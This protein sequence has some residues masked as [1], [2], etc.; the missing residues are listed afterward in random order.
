MG[1]DDETGGGFECLKAGA[2]LYILPN[3]AV[4]LKLL[5]K[6]KSI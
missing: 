6:V 3:Y 2:F 5:Q 1:G 4:S